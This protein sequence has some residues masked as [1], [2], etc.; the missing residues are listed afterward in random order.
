MDSKFK[1]TFISKEF[2]IETNYGGISEYYWQI[3]NELSGLGYDVNVISSSNCRSSSQTINNINVSRIL[4]KDKYNS[5]YL[6]YIKYS[7]EIFDFINKNKIQSDIYETSE[8][9]SEGFFLTE[10]KNIITRFHSP[11]FIINKYQPNNRW[12]TDLLPESLEYIQ[13]KHCVGLTSPS[14]SLL[15]DIKKYWG[16]NNIQYIPNG[17]NIDNVTNVDLTKTKLK[18]D[19]YN[20]LYVGRIEFRKGVIDLAYAL[21][22]IKNV[23][24]FFVGKDTTYNNSS[25]I[26]LIH[27]ITPNIKFVNHNNNKEEIYK[28]LKE[29]NLLVLP[30]HWDNAPYICLEA[31]CLEIPL[32]VSDAGG[33]PEIITNKKEGLIFKSNNVTDLKEKIQFAIENKEFMQKLAKNA[34]KKVISKFNIKK[35]TKETLKYYKTSI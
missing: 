22:E 5:D 33:L 28:I 3:S 32:I 35:T 10:T 13:A 31:M 23:S 20:I 16:L 15:K 24:I 2:P 25:L 21:K 27:K 34:K 9:R 6:S 11:L 19:K 14:L 12:N 8:F 26:K 4:F 30:S 17:I 18:Q 29:G 1:I 7:K